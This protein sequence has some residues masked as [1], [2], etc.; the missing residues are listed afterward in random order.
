MNT[1]KTVLTVSTLAAV[2]S[3]A[4]ANAAF[5]FNPK[6]AQPAFDVADAHFT[7]SPQTGV[8]LKKVTKFGATAPNT[9]T[10]HRP[11]TGETGVF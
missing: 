10:I 2:V 7:T 4:G 9:A 6:P 3:V 1:L 5:A 8:T 11:S